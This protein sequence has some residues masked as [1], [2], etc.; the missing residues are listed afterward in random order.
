[1]AFLTNPWVRYI[2][3]SYEQMKASVLSLFGVKVPEMTDHT[4][5]N[6]YVRMI[7]IF[8]GMHEQLGY[9]VDNQGREAFSSSAR[10]YDSMIKHARAA[11]YKV[12]GNV[13]FTVML[14][15]SIDVP[16]PSDIVIPS[17]TI[18]RVPGTVIDYITTQSTT[19]FTGDTTALPVAASQHTVYSGVLV[20]TA[21]GNA[22]MEIVFDEKIAHDSLQISINGTPWTSVDTLGYSVL[23]TD[24]HYV[25]NVNEQGKVIAQFGNGT[26]G[27]I[28]PTGG[29]IT[30]SYNTTLGA[31]GA[32][33]ENTITEVVSTVALPVGVA[34]LFVNN[35]Y[36][37]TGGA[38]V[39]NIQ[40][41]KTN[42]PAAVR[43]LDRAVTPKDL[44]DVALMVPGVANAGATYSCSEGA[45]IYIV[46]E[47]GGIA[48]PLLLAN[49]KT[50]I[51]KRIIFT[52]DTVVRSAGEIRQILVIDVNVLPGHY[53]AIV[54]TAVENA[55]EVFGRY[56]YQTIGGSVY[57][58]DIYQVI[59]ATEGVKN[60]V[61]RDWKAV[62]YALPISVG[63]PELVWTATPEN[64][65]TST[66]EWMIL[67]TTSSTF[68]LFRQGQLL[69]VFSVGTPVSLPQITFTIT[70]GGYSSGNTYRFYTY[71][72]N[73]QVLQITEPS[74]PTIL[75]SDITV[76][77]TGGI[78]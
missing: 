34:E 56:D 29:I 16:A 71:P 38:D 69:G 52:I 50:F 68:Q 49:A 60:S 48:T 73:P 70:A 6:M 75:L 51:D 20:G 7:D 22:D 23:P 61:I 32:A 8:A 78:A 76:N 53:N 33:N 58:S 67:F 64:G 39:E 24:T 15:F 57:I 54:K 43:T 65:S 30:A 35:P 13:P 44:K 9:Y 40:S 18:C 66:M 1:M 17:G 10:L 55:L 21:I 63:A 12:K 45:Q 28:P 41:L 36:R 59:E 77:V 11:D 37:A 47:G 4:E 27:A 31:S 2:D 62:P 3:R 26:F 42:I 72:A 74:L 25:Q 14:T 19:I 5:S 46:P